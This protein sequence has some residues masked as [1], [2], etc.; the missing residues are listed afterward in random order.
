MKAA[1]ILL[2]LLP[3]LA[4]SL[5]PVWPAPRGPISSGTSSVQVSSSLVVQGASQWPDVAAGVTRFL[6]RAFPRPVPPAYRRTSGAAIASLVLNVS[7]GAESLQLGVDESYSLHIPSDT[8]QPLTLTAA[9][10]FGALLGLETLSQLLLFDAQAKAYTVAGVPLMVED[11]PA[12]QWRGALVDTARHFLPV[13][14]LHAILDSMAFAKLNTLHWHIVD[15]QSWPLESA[16]WPKLWAGAFSPLERYTSEDVEGVVEY[17]RA[18]GIRTVF[19]VDHP[20]HAS[21]ACKGYPQLCPAD[22]DWDAGANSVPLAPASNDTWS[23]LTDTLTEL[24]SLSPDHFLHL[25]GDEVDTTCWALDGPTQ[26]WVRAT[27]LSGVGAIYGV[28]VQRLNAVARSLGRSPLR[29]EDAWTALG[30]ALDPDTVVHVWLS[31][32]TLGNVTSA[33]Y[34]ALYSYQG[35]YNDIFDYQGGWYLNGLWQNWQQMYDVDILAGL[36][37]NASARPLVLGGE[38]AQ[39]GES[40]DGSDV[41]Q[42]IWPRAAAIAER[43]WSYDMGL[44]SSDPGVAERL[45]GFRCLLLQRGVPA[46]PLN[47]PIGRSPPTGPGS[48]F[49]Q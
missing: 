29:W 49:N 5:L 19:E 4:V 35:V 31:P 11:S 46:T 22:C 43:L 39:W 30:T 21:S 2:A 24:A 14:T 47:T 15:A 12:F 8:T 13:A 25:G 1:A 42:T 17:A 7:R 10:Q 16:A 48:C 38:A 18:R 3:H 44:N 36:H 20:G 9:T 33:G 26:A 27:G 34:R 28:F 32:D 40:A 45:A 37:G 6:S 41:L 23:V